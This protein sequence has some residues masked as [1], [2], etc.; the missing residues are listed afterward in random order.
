MR[1]LLIPKRPHRGYVLTWLL[2]GLMTVNIDYNTA[3]ADVQ[4][5]V[6]V[7]AKAF[8]TTVRK[9][10]WRASKAQKYPMHPL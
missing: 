6:S 2:S 3:V 4:H 8:S 10:F 5:H 9:H 7:L 1:D